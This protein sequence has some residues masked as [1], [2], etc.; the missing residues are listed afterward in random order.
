MKTV[1]G[2]YRDN[3]IIMLINDNDVIVRLNFYPIGNRYAGC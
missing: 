1:S 3:D 2:K